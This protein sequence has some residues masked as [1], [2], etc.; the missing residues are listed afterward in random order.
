MRISDWSSD[1]CSSDLRI[2]TRLPCQA[3]LGSRSTTRCRSPAPT[4]N[5]MSSEMAGSAAPSAPSPNPLISSQQS[6]LKSWM[7]NRS[8]EA[9]AVGSEGL[10]E[11]VAAFGADVLAVDG[12]LDRAAMRRLI[13]D[14]EDEIGRAHV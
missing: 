1:V 8:R 14:D 7:E 3:R 10:A 9:V 13:F 11:V 2:P 4:L 5:H 12:A 6:T